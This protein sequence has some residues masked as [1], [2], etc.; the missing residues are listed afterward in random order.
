MLPTEFPRKLG[1]K[2]KRLREHTP[3]SPDELAVRV[4]A[5]SGAEILAYEN[6]EGELPVSV[7]LRYA[8]EFGIPVENIIYDDRDLWF[9]HR[10]N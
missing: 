5:T 10:V 8:K 4:G 7:L 9:G 3:L 6:D 1:E 2:L